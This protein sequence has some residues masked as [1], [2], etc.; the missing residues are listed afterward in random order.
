MEAAARLQ[1]APGFT[2]RLVDIGDVAQAEGDR[3]AVER[4]VGKR[5][6]LGIAGRPGEPLQEATIDGAIT[7]DLTFTA[8]S[9]EKAEINATWN[10]RDTNGSAR[11]SG[12]IGG[13]VISASMPAP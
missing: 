6:I 12:Q 2:Q 3:V 4:T 8:K 9:G 11:L 7:A 10:D 5:Q 13:R 1:D